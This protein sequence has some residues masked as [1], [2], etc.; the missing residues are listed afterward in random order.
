MSAASS[1]SGSTSMHDLLAWLNGNQPAITAVASIL[2]AFA[3][4]MTWLCTVKA[5]WSTRA[6]V[7]VVESKLDGLHVQI[8]SRMDQLLAA[9]RAAGIIQGHAD[10]QGHAR[11]QKDQA[12]GDG[13]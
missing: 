13:P 5:Y 10:R 3:A 11:R 8:N 6:N 1:R 4:V 2:V 12:G 7:L 9:A